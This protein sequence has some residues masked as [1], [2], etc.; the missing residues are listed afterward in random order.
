ML[1][2]VGQVDMAVYRA[3]AGSPTPMLD[4][5]MRRLSAATNWSRLWLVVGG[6]MAVG[7]AVPAG[8]RPARAS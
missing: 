6:A 7:V 3:I 1:G 5:P 2:E 8:G 4:R